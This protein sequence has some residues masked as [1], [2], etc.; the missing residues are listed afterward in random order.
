MTSDKVIEHLVRIKV[1]SQNG[2]IAGYSV[3]QILGNIQDYQEESRNNA[4]KG[5]KDAP[6]RLPPSLVPRARLVSEE[7][8]PNCSICLE[9]LDP[10]GMMS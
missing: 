6:K 5:K 4:A 2:E 10:K 1:E 7:Q 9:I 8:D 3:D